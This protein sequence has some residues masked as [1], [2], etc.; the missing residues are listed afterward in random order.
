MPKACSEAALNLMDCL[1]KTPCF[2]HGGTIQECMEP[3]EAPE[4]QHLRKVYFGCKHNQL[5]MRTRIRGNRVYWDFN[6]FCGAR[7]FV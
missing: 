4:C 5:N 1:E 7:F 6:Y 2:Q 3:K